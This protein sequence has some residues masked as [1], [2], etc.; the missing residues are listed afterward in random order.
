LTVAIT[1]WESPPP[2]LYG[3]NRSKNLERALGVIAFVK[4]ELPLSSAK[5]V[6]TRLQ[7]ATGAVLFVEL[8]T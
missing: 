8:S 6:A 4:M 7:L 5:F 2:L 3:T 1:D